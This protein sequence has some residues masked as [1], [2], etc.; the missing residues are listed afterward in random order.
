MS[1]LTRNGPRLEQK[2]ELSEEIATNQGIDAEILPNPNIIRFR[3][4]AQRM[5]WAARR[6]ATRT[7]DLAYSLL[8][9]FGINMNMLYGEGENAFVRL[10]KEIMRTSK[11]LSL[12]A[13]NFAPR[14]VAELDPINTLG[15]AGKAKSIWYV[16]EDGIIRNDVTDTIDFSR[17]GLF[18]P[19]PS[20]FSESGDIVFLGLNIGRTG[21]YENQGIVKLSAP[22]ITPVEPMIT[23]TDNSF[24]QRGLQVPDTAPAK[25]RF[26][27]LPCSTRSKPDCFLAMSL[28]IWHQDPLDPQQYWTIRRHFTADIYTCLITSED[29]AE[30]QFSE[31]NID[32]DSEASHLLSESNR[33]GPRL[34]L[35]AT[36]CVNF[37]KM[38]PPELYEMTGCSLKSTLIPTCC[39]L[40][41]AWEQSTSRSWNKIELSQ[42]SRPIFFSGHHRTALPP[43]F[44]KGTVRRPPLSHP[45]LQ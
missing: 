28:Y 29:L 9:I 12:F 16:D 31:V 23:I 27:I 2:Q 43:R 5:S 17:N 36:L 35:R 18:A 37:E 13:W 8:G 1:F 45:E 22:F 14:F 15:A 34:T 19:R 25:Q 40:A 21:I 6:K 26:A 4:V 30:A 24:L 42:R 7:E 10:Q 11:D 32:P 39:I 3:S 44:E 38:Y 33:E 41:P 20:C